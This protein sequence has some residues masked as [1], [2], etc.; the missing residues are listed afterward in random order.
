MRQTTTRNLSLRKSAETPAENQPSL[1]NWNRKPLLSYCWI[2]LVTEEVAGVL[3]MNLL[4]S[5]KA[6]CISLEHLSRMLDQIYLNK[7]PNTPIPFLCSQNVELQLSSVLE[8]QGGVSACLP[9][10][11]SRLCWCIPILLLVTIDSF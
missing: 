9:L 7:N 4:Y 10:F 3:C 2:N 1:K 6:I 5:S 8:I 11:D